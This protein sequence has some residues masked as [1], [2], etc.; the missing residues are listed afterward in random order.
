MKESYDA[1]IVGAG[2]G[3]VVC[4]AYL[5]AGG[6][7]TLVIEKAER[8]GGRMK[9]DKT[10]PG[11]TGFEHWVTFGQGWGGGAWYNAA[12]E[13]DADVSFY[14]IPEPCLYYRG[15]GKGFE[16]APRCSSASSLLSYY[17][18]LFP[19]PLPDAT[20][21]E[22]LRAFNYAAS[23]PYEDLFREPLANI[24]F[25]DWK[26]KLSG[27]PQVVAF[28]ASIAA[29]STMCE[30][31]EAMKHLSAGGLLSIFR[32]WW[33]T[34]AHCVAFKPD[35]VDGL[36]MPF[37]RAMER[38]GGE[39]ALGCEVVEVLVEDGVARGVRVRDESGTVQQVSAENVVVN[40]N[41]LDIPKVLREVP[42]EVQGPIDSFRSVAF[43][44]FTVYAEMK[45][46]VTEEPH[47][48]SVVDPD[49]G[50]NLLMIWALSNAFSWYAPPGKQLIFASRVLPI[51]EEERKRVRKTLKQEM[52]DII[53]EV[54]PGYGDAVEKKHYSSHYPLWHYQHTWYPKIPYRSA[55]VKSLFFVG[56]CVEPQQS[57][58]VDAAASTGVFCGKAI[59]R[60]EGRDV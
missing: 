25:Y 26:D 34:E 7:D 10:S 15:T 28:F 1:I 29:N 50:G 58:T 40:A 18:S 16:I 31:D 38:D 44:D 56:D 24:P 52:D 19:A 9:L 5:A 41:F 11:F 46:P 4:G 21:Q 13:L 57:V 33:M 43:H 12:R 36:V 37:V 39:L 17:E 6:L 8:A 51:D 55:S 2:I 54:F 3:G 48:V 32:F 47:P 53:E 42:S 49:T 27:D 59:L 60:M 20:R 45:R 14:E 23:I 35:Y 30:S 22:F